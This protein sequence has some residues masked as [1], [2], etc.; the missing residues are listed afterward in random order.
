MILFHYKILICQKGNLC[1]PNGKGLWLTKLF[2]AYNWEGLNY[3]KTINNKKN[4]YGI[5][6]M[7]Q[8]KKTKSVVNSLLPSKLQRF[9]YLRML[10]VIIPPKNIYLMK[11]N[12]N[13]GKILIRRID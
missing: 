9:L 3:S 12:L 8:K 2:K 11:K 6:G 4:S 1:P 10:R 5:Y 7:I 13:N